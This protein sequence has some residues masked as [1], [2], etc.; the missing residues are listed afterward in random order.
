MKSILAAAIVALG[1][2]LATYAADQDELWEI[3][4]Q[5][6]MPGMPAGMGAQTSK[7]CQDKDP[8]KHAVQGQ[9]ENCKVTDTKQSGNRVTTTVKCPDSNLVIDNTYNAA[10]TE[11]KG[12]MKSTG[13]QGDMTMAM[14]GRKVGSCDA[15]QARNE[16]STQQAKIQGT[17]DKAAADSKRANDEQIKQCA[18]AVDTM[19]ASKLGVYAQCRQN[20]ELCKAV[21]SAPGA[22][23]VSDSC[24]ARQNEFCKRYQTE[25]GFVKAKADPNAAQMCGVSVD[26]VKA[27]LCPGAAQKESLE[28]L[29]RYCP[30]QAKPLAQQHCAG[31]DFTALRASGGKGDKYSAFCYAYLSNAQLETAES[32]SAPRRAAAV[33]AKAGEAAAEKPGDAPKNAADA[34]KTSPADAPKTS[35]ADA[36]S[37]GVTQGINKLRGLF[38]R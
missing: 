10:R 25:A 23:Q 4:T 33:R 34:P 5:M 6:N 16:R 32:E 26:G 7:V 19:D 24:T 2:P 36:V 12:T 17:L 9:N 13:G 18:V 35:P 28:F 29:G 8:R 15:Q 11:F 31:R 3:T 27:S 1:L 20:P 37:E 14:S 21:A 30:V 22:K 38:G